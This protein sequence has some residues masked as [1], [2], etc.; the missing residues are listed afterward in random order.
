MPMLLPRPL[1]GARQTCHKGSHAYRFGSLEVQVGDKIFENVN[2]SID[3]FAII[4]I[5]MLNSMF[6]KLA[7]STRL[8]WTCFSW[9]ER[10]LIRLRV[11]LCK[12]RFSLVFLLF[13][14]TT[15]HISTA[16]FVFFL[17]CDFLFGFFF[18][19]MLSCMIP[20]F[21]CMVARMYLCMWSRR[22]FFGRSFWERSLLEG[23]HDVAWFRSLST[24]HVS[25]YTYV[26]IELYRYVYSIH[27]ILDMYNFRKL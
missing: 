23:C 27:C 22:M 12:D 7:C 10:N 1:Q 21:R 14:S 3:M 6:D 9:W 24:S 2:F 17:G 26:Y 25:T 8:L 20:R 19:S 16:A 11:E 5:I 4:V 18:Y 15:S 13:L